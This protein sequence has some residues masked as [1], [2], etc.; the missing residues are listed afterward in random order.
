MRSGRLMPDPGNP[1]HL[2]R[3]A[4][5]HG[6]RRLLVHVVPFAG[7][8]AR[9]NGPPWKERLV[10]RGNVALVFEDEAAV[11][12]TSSYAALDQAGRRSGGPVRRSCPTIASR[13]SSSTSTIDRNASAGSPWW[14]LSLIAKAGGAWS[15]MPGLP[16]GAC[17]FQRHAQPLQPTGFVGR[18]RPGRLVMRR[19]VSPSRA[20]PRTRATAFSIRGPARASKPAGYLLGSYRIATAP[21]P[22]SSRLDELQVDMPR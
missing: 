10:H 11:A 22:S 18:P 5:R 21:E 13:A 17:W 19:T 15:A 1:S 9:G 2:A 6:V 4:Q 14:C 20:S 8:Q 3:E 7:R 16:P 12:C